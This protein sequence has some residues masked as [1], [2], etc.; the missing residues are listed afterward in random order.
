MPDEAYLR[1][2]VARRDFIVFVARTPD[3]VIGGLTAHMLPSYYTESSEA[4]LYDLAIDSGF[5][6][7]GVGR[8]LLNALADYCRTHGIR[9]FFV[10]ADAPD[11]HAL[12]FYTASGGKPEQVVHYTFPVEK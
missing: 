3:A 8:K 1:T 11:Q 10:Q 6:R 4:Y 7:K 5:R 12:D 9:E 2:L